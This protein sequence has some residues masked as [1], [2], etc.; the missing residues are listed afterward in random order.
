MQYRRK[1]FIILIFFGV[2]GEAEAVF[3]QEI[4]SK[5]SLKLEHQ[6]SLSGR[7]KDIQE[8]QN[9]V[10][11]LE[12]TLHEKSEKLLKYRKESGKLLSA[13]LAFSRP[14]IQKILVFSDATRYAQLSILLKNLTQKTEEAIF[15]LKQEIAEINYLMAL[16]KKQL[17]K[18]NAAQQDLQGRKNQTSSYQE[19]IKERDELPV[20]KKSQILKLSPKNS[21]KN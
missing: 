6:S 3:C 16:R 21:K 10:I 14:N 5:N 9:S 11:L 15:D 12:K 2:L 17:L 18:F 1:V 7:A 8:I 4:S 20:S 13:L 19:E